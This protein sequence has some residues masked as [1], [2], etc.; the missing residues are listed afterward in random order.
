MARIAAA[1]AE[2][3]IAAQPPPRREA[4]LTVLH[5]MRAHVPA[6][7]QE[8]M[9]GNVVNW[10]VPLSR[11]PVTYNRQPLCFASLANT[12]HHCSLHLM[13]IYGSR[14]LADDL[15]AA[16]AALGKKLDMG[17]ACLRF[18]TADALP[19]AAIGA[20]V[21]RVPPEA[22]IAAYEASRPR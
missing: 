15:R 11:Y 5:L 4:L 20:I 8:A 19:L 6:G 9:R 10:E 12:K 18:K 2:E 17:K 22:Y 14:T 3:F 21:A 7:Y 13:C 16:A 1:T